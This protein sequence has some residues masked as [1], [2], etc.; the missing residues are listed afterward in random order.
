[1]AYLHWRRRIRVQTQIRISSPMATFY[2]T[3][4]SHCL[5][6][7]SDTY[8][9]FLYRTGIRVLV[10]NRVT[11]QQCKWT[12]KSGGTFFHVS[13][14]IFIEV[15]E[16]SSQAFSVAGRRGSGGEKSSAVDQ[17]RLRTGFIAGSLQRSIRLPS[18]QKGNVIMHAFWCVLKKNAIFLLS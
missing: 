8:S 11:L 6:S 1:M 4:T 14:I 18:R 5:D 17:G 16:I 9:L 12:I 15:V 2:N 3:E 13:R 7:V 10:H